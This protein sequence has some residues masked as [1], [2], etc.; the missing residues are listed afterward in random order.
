MVGKIVKS[1]EI[2]VL[3]EIENHQNGT[4]FFTE[5]FLSIG[6]AKSINKALE[7]LTNA[8]II[9]RVAT[10]IYTRPEIDPFIGPIT[11]SIESIAQAIATRDKARIV[12]TG[13]YAL[14]KL[15]LSTQVPMKVVYLTDGAARKIQIGKGSILFKKTSPKNLSAIGKIS[16]LVIQA[17]KSI[18]KNNVSEEEIQKIKHVLKNE[19]PANLEHDIYLSPDWIRK[20]LFPILIEIKNDYTCAE[21]MAKTT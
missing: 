13:M 19:K 15:G 14:N 10:G 11:P 18:G 5:S 8:G 16:Q 4:V 17:L 2:N 9:S 21:R 20:I 6:N 12:P 7:R 3:H 1:I